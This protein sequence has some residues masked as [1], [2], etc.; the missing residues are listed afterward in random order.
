[1]KGMT[2]VISW[3]TFYHPGE[4]ANVINYKVSPALHLSLSMP[5]AIGFFSLIPF[6]GTVLLWIWAVLRI[7]SG[8][9]NV[10]G[11]T[12]KTH[13]T[14]QSSHP[15]LPS[16]DYRLREPTQLDIR[17]AW[18]RSASP[19]S[20]PLDSGATLNAYY[21]K[22]LNFR[23]SCYTAIANRHNRVPKGWRKTTFPRHSHGR[24]GMK[25]ASHF[26]KAIILLP[27]NMLFLEEL[28]FMDFYYVWGPGTH[29]LFNPPCKVLWPTNT[30][31]DC[32]M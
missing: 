29:F 16:D 13:E 1:M 6:L 28:P 7:W 5:L 30:H 15:Q 12:F 19:P 9:E 20:W 8:Q 32:G 14:T 27:K 24:Y 23:V 10:V 2:F 22:H 4:G 17:R 21:F 11:M 18:P 25:W 31:K 26:S 3:L